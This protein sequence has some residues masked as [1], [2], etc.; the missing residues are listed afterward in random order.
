MRS[1]DVRHRR[2]RHRRCGCRAHRVAARDELPAKARPHDLSVSGSI[3]RASGRFVAFETETGV[4]GAND[5][6][7]EVTDLRSGAGYP[8]AHWSQLLPFDE[9]P[10]P[11]SLARARPAS[12][13]LLEGRLPPG[14]RAD[15]EVVIPG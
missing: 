2:L 13:L 15:Y 3:L 10:S 9:P 1:A 12:S 14:R 5:W 6:S 7:I 8:V 11:V 4:K